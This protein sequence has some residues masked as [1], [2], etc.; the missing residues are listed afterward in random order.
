MPE[1]H[2]KIESC[3]KVIKSSVY[4]LC[5]FRMSTE[6]ILSC[7]NNPENSYTERKAKHKPSRHAWCS[8]CSFDNIKSKHYFYM[9]KD[10]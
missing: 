1:E 7:Q 10:Y 8:I 6:K 3:R 4:S 9:G 2:E 5:R